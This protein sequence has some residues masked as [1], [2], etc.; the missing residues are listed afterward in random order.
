MKIEA[1]PTVPELAEQ[2]KALQWLAQHNPDA[3]SASSES[4][5]SSSSESS[6]EGD[7]E[8]EEAELLRVC[9]FGW[10]CWIPFAD[11]RAGVGKNQA[12]TC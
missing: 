3:E 12:R 10:C 1:A 5:S 8:D 2:E 11:P 9:G 4:S 7:D 6:S